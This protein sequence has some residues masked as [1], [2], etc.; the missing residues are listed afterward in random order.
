MSAGDQY[1]IPGTDPPEPR[2]HAEHPTV[3]RRA[4]KA[5]IIAIAAVVVAACAALF[6]FLQWRAAD[7]QANIAS[8]ALDVA[9]QTLS[10]TRGALIAIG[11]VQLSGNG[12]QINLSLENI[13][14]LPVRGVTV[15]VDY[16][17]AQNTTPLLRRS[18]MKNENV[19]II[20]QQPV[21]SVLIELPELSQELAARIRLNQVTA[22]IFGSVGYNNGFGTEEAAPFCLN[23]APKTNLWETDKCGAAIV[24]KL[25]EGKQAQ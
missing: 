22:A 2:Q 3:A 10:L 12:K 20:P 21:V 7:K 8:G 1:R 4:N 11:K 19:T 13:G 5:L 17:V 18:A 16:V 14:G 9:K 25:D 23:Y 6:S 24:L 15:K